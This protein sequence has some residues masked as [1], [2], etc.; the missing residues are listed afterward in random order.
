MRP[1]VPPPA[2][3]PPLR[4]PARGTRGTRG[5]GRGEG[6]GGSPL[7]L[8][9]GSRDPAPLARTRTQKAERGSSP[10]CRQLPSSSSC[11]VKVTASR[12]PAHSRGRISRPLRCVEGGGC[13]GGGDLGEEGVGRPDHLF[14]GPMEAGR[15]V[16]PGMHGRGQAAPRQASCTT[17]ARLMRAWSSPPS[18]LGSVEGSL[19]WG[20]IRL[21][22]CARWGW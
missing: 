15:G 22:G 13:I 14:A 9:G 21:D 6:V 8:Q 20:S 12:P 11:G 2:S 19:R 16:P 10:R 1:P 5:G 7:A 4:F 3:P 18:P 17:R